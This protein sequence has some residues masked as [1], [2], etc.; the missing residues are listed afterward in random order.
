MAAKEYT[1]SMFSYKDQKKIIN[2]YIICYITK[3]L[4][5]QCLMTYK[6]TIFRLRNI[7]T[8]Y[9]RPKYG[10]LPYF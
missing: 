6:K 4:V 8:I 9:Y 1:K 10:S 3:R 7:K 5:A 2:E